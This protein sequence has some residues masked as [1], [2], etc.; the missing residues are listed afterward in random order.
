L[1]YLLLSTIYRMTLARTP[2]VALV[3]PFEEKAIEPELRAL[4]EQ[5]GQAVPERRVDDP[6]RLIP[7]LLESEGYRVTRTNLT[8]EDPIP[9]DTNTLVLLEP[10]ALTETQQ[11]AISRFLAK[12]G[13]VLLAAQQYQFDYTTSRIGE[14]TV[15]PRPQSPNVNAL[16]GSW[17]LSLDERLLLDASQDAISVGGGMRLGPFAVNVPLKLPIHIRVNPESM[18]Q[19]LSITSRLSPML[20]LWGSALTV[21]QRALKT[22]NLT[23]QVLMRSSDESWLIPASRLDTISPTARPGREDPRGPFPLAVLVEGEFPD[24]HGPGQPAPAAPGKLLV[25]GAVTPFQEQ[26]IETGGHLHFLLNAVDTLS[27]GED[28]IQIRAKQPVDR[29]IGH[30]SA[31]TKAWWRFFVSFLMPLVIVGVGW[32]R[33]LLRRRATRQYLQLIQA[34]A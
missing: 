3:A 26:L 29:S 22:H 33:L 18:N 5:L 8:D 13:S 11:R 20:Y 14:I 1:E 31:A 15:I 28:L 23:A 16:L 27:L 6:Y 24:A 34:S 9:A 4:L 17:G 12:G 21:D 30:V 10:R 2:R 7:P 19:E 32:M 25:I